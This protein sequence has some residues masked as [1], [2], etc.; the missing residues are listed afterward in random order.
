MRKGMD[1][2]MTTKQADKQERVVFRA[3]LAAHMIPRRSGRYEDYERA[4]KLITRL[5]SSSAEY[6]SMIHQAARWVKV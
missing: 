1:Y 2:S 4:K 5:A 6:D 3:L